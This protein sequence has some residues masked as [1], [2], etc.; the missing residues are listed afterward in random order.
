MEDLILF[1]QLLY[2]PEKIEIFD[3]ELELRNNAAN[4]YTQ[5]IN[6]MFTSPHIPEK[7]PFIMGSIFYFKNL[8]ALKETV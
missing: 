4:Y 5:N 2:S 8:K 7:I 3:N 6:K 1:K